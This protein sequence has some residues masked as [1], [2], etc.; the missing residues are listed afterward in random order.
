[1]SETKTNEWNVP[2]SDDEL[3]ICEDGQNLEDERLEIP[4]KV[5]LL[6]SEIEKRGFIELKVKEFRDDT[7]QSAV[8]SS[9]LSKEVESQTLHTPADNETKQSKEVGETASAGKLIIEKLD[10]TPEPSAF[11]YAEESIDETSHM[12][13]KI[14]KTERF[15]RKRVGTLE[16]VISDLKRFRDMNNKGD[17]ETNNKFM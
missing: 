10:K 13:R 9:A 6:Y 1:M 8:Q 4:L 3:S 17:G 12:T 2:S 14:P 5:L 11:D 7:K 16:N 15:Q